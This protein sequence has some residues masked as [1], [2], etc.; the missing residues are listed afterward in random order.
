ML[1]YRMRKKMELEEVDE[2]KIK[3][4]IKY[5]EAGRNG[6]SESSVSGMRTFQ[7]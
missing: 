4:A 6:S 1:R 7:R 2:R 5:L 3:K